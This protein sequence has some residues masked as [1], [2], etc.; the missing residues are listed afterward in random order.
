MASATSGAG[1][2]DL[3]EAEHRKQLRRAVIASTVGTTIEWY[4]FLL[5]ATVTGLVFAHLYFP[6]SDPLV[7]TLQAYAIFFVGFVARPIGAAI[8]G[9]YGDR[10]GRKA[11]LIATLLLTGLATVLVALV[12]TYEQIGIWGAIILILL[13]FIQ[14]VGVGGE[15][16]GSV[17]LAMEW[18]RTDKDRGF[19]ASWPQFGGPAGIALANL[20]VLVFSAISGDQFLSWG[21]RIPFLLSIVMVA[22]GLYIR[23]GIFETPVFAK[24][25]AEEQVASAPVLEV[26]RQHPKEIVL[27][28]LA[29][30]AEQG[31]GYVY[32]AFIFTYGTTILGQ[33]RDLLLAGLLTA[34]VLGFLWVPVA[35]HLSDRIGRRRM[36]MIGAVASGLYGFAYFALL[37]TLSPIWIFVGIA[38]SLIPVMTLYGPQAALIAESFSPALRYSGAGIGYQAASIIAGGP[39]PF[40]ATALYAEFQSGYAIVY[41]ILACGVISII[42]AALLK[43][44]TNKDLTKAYGRV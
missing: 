20:A 6:Q 28:A 33:P 38:L 4:D 35:G 13:R 41:Y 18:T 9:H 24:V 8:F 22:I 40:I 30:M 11:A 25:V 7:G 3:S 15:W 21:W 31:P 10:I 23:L 34:A 29:R 39:A 42:A 37:N 17:L 36:Y 12:P 26:F 19:I 16:S 27:T 43:D 2:S 5:Y 14:G 1:P 32:I 44:Y